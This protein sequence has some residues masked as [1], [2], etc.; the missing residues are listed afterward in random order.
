MVTPISIY[1]SGICLAAL[2]KKASARTGHYPVVFENWDLLIISILAEMPG[3][4]QAGWLQKYPVLFGWST[5]TVWKLWR[6]ET[7]SRGNG[8]INH[9]FGATVFIR[10]PHCRGVGFLYTTFL[11]CPARANT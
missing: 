1:Y 2:K 9:V 7:R 3:V 5:E 4:A 11:V 10:L 8:L 6:R